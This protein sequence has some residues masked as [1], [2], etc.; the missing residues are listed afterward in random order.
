MNTPSCVSQFFSSMCISFCLFL[1]ALPMTTQADMMVV[2]MPEMSD[3]SDCYVRPRPMIYHPQHFHRSYA[4][5]HRHRISYYH[6]QRHY[7]P[8][9]YY[10][11]QCDNGF[12]N[13]FPTESLDLRTGDDVYGDINNY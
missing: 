1:F 4:H 10:T 2:Y 13:E 8:I 12:L 3:E 6:Y 11:R 5:Y 9:G 7:P